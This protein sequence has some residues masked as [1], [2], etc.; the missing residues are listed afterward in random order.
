M[1]ITI[2]RRSVLKSSCAV[3]AA[4][5]GAGIGATKAEAQTRSVDAPAERFYRDEYF[6]D[7]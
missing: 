3:G 7:P 4:V 1:A 5:A 6:G 2:S